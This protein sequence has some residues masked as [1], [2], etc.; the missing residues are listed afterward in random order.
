M[1]FL[2]KHDLC[3]D[4]YTI[5]KLMKR[6]IILG[7]GMPDY[8]VLY[9]QR[10]HFN[11][12]VVEYKTSAF[13]DARFMTD[14]QRCL[15]Y[16]EDYDL[17]CHGRSTMMLVRDF[18][19]HTQTCYEAPELSDRSKVADERCNIWT[20]GCL[21]QKVMSLRSHQDKPHEDADVNSNEDDSGF[22]HEITK[23]IDE[24][25]VKWG[26]HDRPPFREN[27]IPE[28]M[29]PKSKYHVGKY[30]KDLCQLVKQCIQADPASRPSLEEIKRKC[31][32][33]LAAFQK[34]E[35]E[36]KPPSKKEKESYFYYQKP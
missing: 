19:P 35:G 9:P 17:S 5:L 12:H 3:V 18:D 34:S 31:R 32:K 11:Q 16:S 27:T 14:E 15:Y 29:N 2:A 1:L 25:T 26:T 23:N 21:V 20:L 28:W 24:L 10:V 13:D 33:M 6:L 30:S 36:Q 4:E 22:I 7:E 8:C